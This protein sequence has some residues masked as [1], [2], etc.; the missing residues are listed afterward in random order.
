[1]LIESVHNNIVK[2]VVSLQDKQNRDNNGLFVVEGYKQVSDIPETW[3]IEYVICTEKYKDINFKA[4]TYSA[5]EAVFK[6]MSETK[7]PQGILAVVKKQKRDLENILKEK[8][9]FVVIDSL[10]DPGNLGSIIRTAAA[11]NCKGIFLSK[12][13]VDCFSGKAVRS[14]MG[15]VFNVPL[16]QE[17]DLIVLMT[18][19][20]KHNI[21]TYALALQTDN[22]L[23]NTA[24]ADSTAVI[25]GNEADGVGENILKNVDKLVKIEMPG[26]AQSLNAAIACS[27]AVYE[28]FRQINIK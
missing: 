1:M 10:Q 21:K 13:T 24:F 5:S 3:D 19:F 4:K 15:A 14:S 9:I 26:K 20:K 23:A 11:Y 22:L 28:I 2:Q 7:T 12:N 17:C 25:V 6:K 16:F 27:I 8:G 18:A